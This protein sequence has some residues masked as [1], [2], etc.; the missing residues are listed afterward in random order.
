[1][2]F[3]TEIEITLEANPG[4]INREKLAAFREIGINRLSIGVQSFQ[5]RKLETL[6]RIHRAKEALQTIET[7]QEVGFDNINIDLMYGLP[8]Q[9][10]KDALFDLEQ[11]LYFKP[12]HLS[13]YQLTIELNTP[14]G[15]STPILPTEATF[16][17][18]Q[19]QGQKFI[20]TYNSRRQQSVTF[21]DEELL[22][23]VKRYTQYEISAYSL[24]NRECRHNLNYWTFG[25]YLGIGA[26]A[27]S[28]ITHPTKQSI[29]RYWKLKHPLDYLNAKESFLAGQKKLFKK[30][31]PLEFMMN[32]LR[33]TQGVP[34][35]LFYERTG[36]AL[37][38]IKSPLNLAKE[39]GF[40][41]KK[42]NVLKTTKLGE[43]FLNNCLELFID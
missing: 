27:H 2:V 8:R 41:V 40:L 24:P 34:T 35:S 6:G 43:Q 10:V 36:L 23:K 3:S 15:Q 37:N 9:T 19:K 33:L 31:L 12:A 22:S 25:D 39:K 14:F 17:E 5:D 29:T 38:N 1:M 7:A 13:W 20:K 30:E 26:G 42:N 21:K 16:L 28:K 11:A 18:I 32:A 4:S